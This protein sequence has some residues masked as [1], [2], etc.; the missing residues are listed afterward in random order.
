MAC[1]NPISA[2]RC[3]VSGEILFSDKGIGDRLDLPC[4]QCIGCR[5]E[6]SRQ[7]ATRIMFESQMHKHNCFITLTY[8]NDFLPNPPSLRYSDFQAF[9]KR[10][11]KYF[12]PTKV[13]FYMCG[14]YGDNNFRPHYHAIL[15]GVDFADR[16][17]HSR[18]SAGYNIDRSATLER[19]WPFGYS[20]IADVTFE[21]AAYVARYVMKKV[22]GDLAEDHYAYVCPS[23][24]EVSQLV[25]E[26]NRMS[27]RPGIGATWFD[28]YFTS[29]MVNDS[30]VINGVECKPPRYFD[31]LLERRD[32]L[33]M[34]E[35]KAVRE[36]KAY[37]RRDD[38]SSRRLK[39]REIVKRASLE[40]LNFGRGKFDG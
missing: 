2:Y 34:A 38:N 30:V 25:P 11:R 26:F 33:E 29:D 10:L 7:W 36:F 15:F 24:G 22:T 23:T 28:K 21:S 14:E 17:L 8:S 12:E 31:K 19:L 16:Y 18:T 3:S 20:S 9:M 32:K 5:L 40:K 39:D 6:R 35:R 4:G 13:R 1:Y 37:R 27:L